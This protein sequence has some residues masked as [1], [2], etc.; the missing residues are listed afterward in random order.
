MLC[1][2]TTGVVQA[3]NALHDAALQIADSSGALVQLAS[4]CARSSKELRALVDDT[5]M[6]AQSGGPSVTQ[7]NSVLIKEVYT[8]ANT[9][10]QRTGS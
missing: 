6:Q 1:K 8:V 5:M 2:S 9:L 4:R 7:N 3:M 10:F